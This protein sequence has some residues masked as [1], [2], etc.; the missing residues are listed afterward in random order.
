MYF[1]IQIQIMDF[2][3]KAIFFIALG[4]GVILTGHCAR[5][6]F[7]VNLLIPQIIYICDM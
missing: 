1:E 4:M 5:K 3:Y 7:L 2:S 6:D